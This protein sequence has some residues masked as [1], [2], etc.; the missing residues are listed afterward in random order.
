MLSPWFQ[1]TCDRP[2]VQIP[3]E[4]FPYVFAFLLLIAWSVW[5]FVVRSV[6][7]EKEVPKAFNTVL[8]IFLVVEKEICLK[9]ASAEHGP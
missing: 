7:T 1:G 9:R 3:V 5:R 2:R 8:M 6:E 4:P